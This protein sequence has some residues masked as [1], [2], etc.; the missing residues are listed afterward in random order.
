MSKKLIFI[1][2]LVTLILIGLIF[3]LIQREAAEIIVEEPEPTLETEWQPELVNW[4]TTED[5]IDS[6]A[7]SA[8]GELV[9]AGQ[10]LKAQV[11]Q[12]G[13][14]ELAETFEFSHS[15]ED[16]EF[17][18]NNNILAGG[19]TLGG[20]VLYNLNNSQ[21]LG[22]LN[23]GYNSRLSFSPDGNTIATAN[24]EGVVWIWDTNNREQLATL[25]PEN[26][27]FAMALEYSSDGEYI[28]LGNMAG[29]ICYWQVENEELVH[30]FE[31]GTYV[32]G[33]SLSP[34]G[35]LLAVSAENRKIHLFDLESGELKDIL[36]TDFA[37]TNLAFSPN[38]EILVAGGNI[39]SPGGDG[40]MAIAWQTSDW[41]TWQIF[42]NPD[43]E[44]E[45][46]VI[47]DVAFSLDGQ[48]L[49]FSSKEGQISVWQV[50]EPE[51]EEEEP[52]N[53]QDS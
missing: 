35:K 49:A 9:A 30:N 39:N 23:K 53:N 11:Y 14:G 25:E 36:E 17:S 48:R 26:T 5:G 12:A 1:I 32:Q 51:V 40:N 50:I 27:D 8:N 31:V 19:L 28:A 29:E 33:L 13:S 3:W 41:S 44:S 6:I 2:A 37:L 10:Y 42:K 7:L 46:I 16:L 4:L 20:V 52:I 24:R 43:T 47:S 21:E 15:V 45:R 38:G 18:P 34:D 22:Q